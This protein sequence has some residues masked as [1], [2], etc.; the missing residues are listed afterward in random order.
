M[1]DHDAVSIA[2]AASVARV[3]AVLAEAGMGDVIRGFPAGTATAADAAA[4]IGCTV[5]QIAKS[6]VFRSGEQPVLVI[7]SG[8]N[9]V[10]KAKLA[11]VIG[12]KVVPA[13][14]DFVWKATGFAAGGVSPLGHVGPV[15]IVIDQDLTA[16]EVVWAAA[17][18]AR[19]V[20]PIA[21][22]TLVRLTRGKI[23]NIRQDN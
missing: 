7:A 6:I 5:A 4:A 16:F 22:D 14:P 10:S 11:P 20:F 19:H 2:E 12:A 15:V 9:R 1:R 21:P 17:G 13:G 3:R 18:S 8:I 23:A